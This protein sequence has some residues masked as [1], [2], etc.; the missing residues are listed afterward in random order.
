MN[1]V[2][3]YLHYCYGE[4]KIILSKLVLIVII[5]QCHVSVRNTEQN[6]TRLEVLES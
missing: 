6:F 4:Q 2:N 5:I 1:T 3:F